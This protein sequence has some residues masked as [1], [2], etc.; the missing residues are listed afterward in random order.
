MVLRFVLLFFVV[1]FPLAAH[2]HISFECRFQFHQTGGRISGV[3][4]DWKFDP[5]FSAD[6]L[7]GYDTNRDRT[8]DEAETRQV[9]E[10]AFVSLKYYHYFTF[11]RQGA[12][13]SSPQSVSEFRVREEDG[14][15]HYQF[16]VDLRAY[17]GDVAL[18]VYD[19]TYYCAVSYV[20]PTLPPDLTGLSLTAT[21]ARE[22]PVYYNPLGAAD[23][24][25][26]YTQW[27]P[28]LATFYPTEIVVHHAP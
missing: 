13:R 20:Y 19:H 15:V 25:T 23:D 4:L 5:F 6:I 14:R 21:T 3:T 22:F 7:R 10:Q 27:K 12:T 9:F 11:I 8:F 26:T 17:Q 2:P 18:A 16:L 28:G 24:L 1:G